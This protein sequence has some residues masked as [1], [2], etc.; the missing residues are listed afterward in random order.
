[1]APDLKHVAGDKVQIKAK[2]HRFAQQ[3][4][5]IERVQGRKL[6]VRLNA[7]NS[8]HCADSAVSN[9][10]LA[11]RKAWAKMPN[12]KV[13]RPKGSRVSDRVSVTFRVDRDIW[14]NFRALEQ[15]GKIQDRVH[16]MNQCLQHV[17]DEVGAPELT[18]PNH[19]TSGD[20]THVV[21]L[22]KAIKA[23]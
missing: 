19:R 9:Y 4:G 14:D 18:A 10:S 20:E 3:R 7:G 2:N 8:F 21:S 22:K 16:V 23:S 6:S 15:S 5:V 1:M 11:A 17:I 13:G 12:R